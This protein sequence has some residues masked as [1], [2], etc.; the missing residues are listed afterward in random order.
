V[1]VPEARAVADAYALVKLLAAR[2]PEATV[3]LAVNR[4]LSAQAARSVAARMSR[5][6][7]RFIGRPLHPLGFVFEDPVVERAAREGGAFVTA[8]GGSPAA[9]CVTSMAQRLNRSARSGAARS[10]AQCVRQAARAP[11]DPLANAGAS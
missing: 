10:L 6:A 5:V 3:H 7:Q 2:H 8:H 9:R 11:F 1:T 4:A